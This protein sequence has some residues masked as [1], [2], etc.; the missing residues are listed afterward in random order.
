MVGLLSMSTIKEFEGLKLI[1]QF[2]ANNGALKLVEEGS[3]VSVYRLENWLE[4]GVLSDE[5]KEKLI[6]G[7]RK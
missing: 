5:D 6:N 3:G 2:Y 1:V 4:G 7:N